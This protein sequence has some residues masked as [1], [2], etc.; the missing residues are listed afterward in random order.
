MMVRSEVGNSPVIHYFRSVAALLLVTLLHIG[1]AS[2]AVSAEEPSTAIPIHATQSATPQSSVETP[3]GTLAQGILS[4]LHAIMAPPSTPDYSSASALAISLSYPLYG[5]S[6]DYGEKSHPYAFTGGGDNDESLVRSSYKM[7]RARAIEL[8][9][10]VW[11]LSKPLEDRSWANCSA[12]TGTVINNTLD[13]NFPSNLVRNQYAYINKPENGWVK[14]GAAANYRPEKYKPGDIFI[15]NGGGLS[16]LPDE[17]GGHTFIW[18]G[19][20]NGLKEVIAEAAF[21]SE[22]SHGAKLPV[23]RINALKDGTDS[24]GR[25]YEVRRFNGKPGGYEDGPDYSSAKSLAIDLAYPLYE[26]GTEV[27]PVS[28]TGGGKRDI[29]QASPWYYAARQRANELGTAAGAEDLAPDD[30]QF[31]AASTFVGTVIQNTI[32][33]RFPGIMIRTQRDYLADPA[34]NWIKVG[35]TEKYKPSSYEP[36]D[37][38]IT[39]NSNSTVMIWIGDRAGLENVIADAA[40]GQRDSEDARLP[41]LRV[42]TLSTSGDEFGRQYDVYRYAATQED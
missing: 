36:G 5:P 28:Y 7:A 31:A 2:P 42:S 3:L 40:H 33:A 27:A 19:D 22:S 35:S 9:K 38:L 13:P 30:E 34:N 29:G 16:S 10:N 25:E 41:G 14:V 26:K 24:R 11:N 1:G 17:Q 4:Q 15:T 6:K 37:V 39:R 20:Y 21:G 23:L 12:F 18:I 8:T 32:D